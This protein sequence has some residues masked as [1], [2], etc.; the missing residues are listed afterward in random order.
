MSSTIVEH[1]GTNILCT[2]VKHQK[3]EHQKF[4]ARCQSQTQVKTM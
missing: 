3:T 1:S 2:C 4:T